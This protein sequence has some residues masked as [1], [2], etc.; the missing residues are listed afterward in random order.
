MNEMIVS[1]F[2]VFTSSVV[3]IFMVI[4][5]VIYCRLLE[6]MSI[7]SRGSATGTHAFFVP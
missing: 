5:S 6:V 7:S 1:K 3:V 4:M 2:T